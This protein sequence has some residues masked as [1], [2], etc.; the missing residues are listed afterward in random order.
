MQLRNF[1]FSSEGNERAFMTK[2]YAANANPEKRFFVSL[3]TRDISLIDAVIDLTDNSVNA[4]MKASDNKF[5]TSKDF[6]KLIPHKTSKPPS[7][8]T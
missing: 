6:E 7:T 1:P 8:S 3:L 5:N 4:A 2:L